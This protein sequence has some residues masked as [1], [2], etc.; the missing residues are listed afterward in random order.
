MPVAVLRRSASDEGAERDSSA[1]ETAVSKG[2]YDDALAGLKEAAHRSATEH[3]SQRPPKQLLEQLAEQCNVSQVDAI[4]AAAQQRV[5]LIHGPPGTGKV[6]PPNLSTASLPKDP[7]KHWA[8]Y[9]HSCF[10]F[11]TNS[12][13]SAGIASTK[14]CHLPPPSPP[15]PRVV[16]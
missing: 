15:P 10:A 5:T 14:A 8:I 6:S 1:A 7:L 16:S 2:A 13:K 9:T 11:D 3:V 4:C 12:S